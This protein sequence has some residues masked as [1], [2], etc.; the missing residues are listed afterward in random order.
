MVQASPE[1]IYRIRLKE[2]KETL[3]V[4]KQGKFD[5]WYDKGFDV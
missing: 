1:S 4:D 3:S 2:E 5:S